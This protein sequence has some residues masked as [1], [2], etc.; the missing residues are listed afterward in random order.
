MHPRTPVIVGTGQLT[1]RA[2]EPLSPL[3]LMEEA[4]RRAAADAGVPTLLERL[5]SVVVVDAISQLL[6]D[7]GTML[8]QQLG[9]SPQETVRSG[10]GGNGPQL[11]VN[12]IATRI[13]EDGLDV[14]LI[15]G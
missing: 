11:A 15:A 4:A 14:A 13:A 3:A 1:T 10:L 8:A 12:D 2:G 6:G 9:A 5:Q 7:P